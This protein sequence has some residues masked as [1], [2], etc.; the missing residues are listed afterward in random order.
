MTEKVSILTGKELT[1]AVSRIGAIA[2][3]NLATP[4]LVDFLEGEFSKYDKLLPDSPS[5]VYHIENLEFIEF[6]ILNDKK[7]AKNKTEIDSLFGK[8]KPPKKKGAFWA[9]TKTEEEPVEVKELEAP[10]T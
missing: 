7:L 9:K 3:S 1:T 5:L 6:P 2:K 10:S 8:K 4:E